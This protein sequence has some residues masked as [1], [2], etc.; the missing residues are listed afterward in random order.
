M[1]LAEA[2]A[3]YRDYSGKTSE[4]VRQLG[5]AGLALVWILS[6]DSQRSLPLAWPL[7]LLVPAMLI[8]T[9]LALDLVHYLAA[10]LL[11]GGYHRRQER[12]G[13]QETATVLAPRWVNWPAVT[14]FWSKSLAMI[15]A[16]WVLLF[17]TLPHRVL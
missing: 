15:A 5:F 8:V 1:T 14:F 16:Y 2:G 11:W 9:S 17:W 10:S 3:A 6:T 13:V 4:I 7:E 12:A